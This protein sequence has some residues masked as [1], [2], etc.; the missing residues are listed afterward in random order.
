M[1][2]YVL[3]LCAICMSRLSCTSQKGKE[4]QCTSQGV[5]TDP[6][7]G[8]AVT[9]QWPCSTATGPNPW[10]WILLGLGGF[11]PDVG[12]FGDANW[13]FWSF[14]P[15][16]PICSVRMISIWNFNEIHGAVA[17]EKKG[18]NWEALVETPNLASR[19]CFV[20]VQFHSPG[21]GTLRISINWLSR[22]L[23]GQVRL[24][25][26][27]WGYHGISPVL[28]TVAEPHRNHTA[29]GASPKH[30]MTVIRGAGNM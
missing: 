16:G 28:V 18:R 21:R 9:A 14:E 6:R 15:F 7:R 30:E 8:A 11:W 26:T 19:M 3:Y 23:G 10:N 17:V 27:R 2:M 22:P 29:G 20:R 24:G 5:V 13:R 25:D 1:I 12:G 4:R